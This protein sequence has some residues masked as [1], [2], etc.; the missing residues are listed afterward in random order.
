MSTIT[1]FLMTDKTGKEI[2]DAIKKVASAIDYHSETIYGFHVDPA[3]S[4]PAAAVTYL[5]DAIGMTPAGMEYDANNADNS[6]FNYGSW[7]NAFFMPRP[8]LLKRDGTVEC[9]LKPNDYSKKEDGTAA[10]I[11]GSTF[12]GN[13]MMEWGQNGKK[14]WYK[15]VAD[16]VGDGYSVYIADHRADADYHAWSFIN[17]QGAMV[18]HFYT[19]VYGGSLVS[20]TLRSLSGKQLMASKTAE[21]EITYAKANNDG[22]NVLWFTETFSDHILIQLLLILM[23]KSLDSQSVFGRG[24][25]TGSQSACEAYRTG[26][27]N[28]KGLFFGYNDSTHTVKVFGM[29]NYWAC[30]WRR[31]AGCIND[32]GTYKLKYTYGTQDGSTVNGYPAT[33]LTTAATFAG[34]IPSG[35]VPAASSSYIK[36]MHVTAEGAIVPSEVGGSSASYYCDGMWSNNGQVDYAFFGGPSANGALCGLFAWLVGTPASYAAW[37]IGAALSCKPLV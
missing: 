2:R 25:E 4:D 12:T 24:I 31:K 3:E 36:K 5:M 20:E 15:I 23:G 37:D 28:S 19:P 32:N 6:V 13:V 14:I 30:Q 35:S 34:Y 8:C 26:Q 17:N 10:D 18:D 29:E 21:A 1:E 16:T 33:S 9:Y 7:E 11:E 27:F 22:T